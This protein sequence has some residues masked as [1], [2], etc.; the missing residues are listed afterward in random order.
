MEK[1]LLSMLRSADLKK[2]SFL[3]LFFVFVFVGFK[4]F[5]VDQEVRTLFTEDEVH[6][7]KSKSNLCRHYV[8][9][10]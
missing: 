2:I 5:V 9:A 1:T 3:I 7:L 8:L 10:K 6:Y 4:I